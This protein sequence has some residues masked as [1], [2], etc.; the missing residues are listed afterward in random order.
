MVSPTTWHYPT[1]QTLV[2]IFQ[3]AR[4]RYPAH[5]IT[6]VKIML[7]FEDSEEKNLRKSF[8]RCLSNVWNILAS[9]QR[10]NSEGQIAMRENDSAKFQR[11]LSSQPINKSL[12]P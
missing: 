4:A 9:F 6:T 3:P 11:Q 12:A 7:E 5:N 10:Y 1:K 8:K 2:R